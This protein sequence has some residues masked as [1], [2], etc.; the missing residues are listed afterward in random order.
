MTP[1]DVAGDLTFALAF[2]RLLVKL[3]KASDAGRGVTLDA[4]EV[5]L[6][7]EA[8]QVLRRGPGGMKAALT[9]RKAKGP[10]S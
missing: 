3:R 7:I 5:R 1:P 6:T 4:D 8:M 10:P 2:A 9:L